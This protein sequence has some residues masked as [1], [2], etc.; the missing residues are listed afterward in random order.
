MFPFSVECLTAFFS[1]TS[2]VSQTGAQTAKKL[3]RLFH[4][5][6]RQR[7]FTIGPASKLWAQRL[8]FRRAEKV[9]VV[10]DSSPTYDAAFDK[11][12]ILFDKDYRMIFSPV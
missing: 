12:L 4:R 9:S 1:R 3:T 7:F 10:F 6:D 5:T 2:R 11:H 8:L